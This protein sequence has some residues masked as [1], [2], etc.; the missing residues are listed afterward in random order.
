MFPAGIGSTLGVGVYVIAGEVAKSMAGP[1]VVLSFL[2]AAIASVFA[3]YEYFEFTI[4]KWDPVKLLFVTKTVLF[5]LISR[6]CYA[7]FSARVPK[8]GSAYV[9]S[10]VTIGEFIAFVIGWNLI[11]EYSIGSASVVKGMSTYIDSLTGMN[12]I[13]EENLPIHIS[14]MA[15]FPDVFAFSV[16]ML[17]SLA[18]AFGARES[19]LMNNVFTFLNLSVV[20]FVIIAGSLKADPNNWSIPADKVPPK[21][22]DGGFFPYGWSGVFKGAATCFYGFIGFDCIA[23]AGEEAKNPR[24]SMPLAI[25]V[26]LFVIF[27]AY[28][29]ISTVLTM[30]LPYYMQ[31]ENAPLPYVFRYYGWET[32]AWAVSIGAIFG[33]CASLLGS[34]FPLPRIVYAMAS[35]GLIFKWL[36]RIN[37]RFHT[38]LYGT[39]FVGLLT[40]SLAAFLN[41]SQ[42][43]NMMSLGTLIAYSIVAACVLLLR[44]EVDDEDEKLHVP[45]PFCYN[46]HRFLCNSF[47]LQK[48]TKLTS[49]I[50]TC[51]V[52][53]FCKYNRWLNDQRLSGI[54]R[55]FVFSFF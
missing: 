55:N 33:L 22:G 2:I 14:G 40:A 34:M 15:E 52:T 50:A 38:P 17:F 26:S 19:S 49:L 10:Y 43:V 46:F 30:M 39:L 31:N 53:L 32:A 16:T 18:L 45:A 35:D 47:N 51:E 5:W 13:F 41:L 23:T 7:E 42:L 11:L 1:A 6:L 54:F 3:G 48:P 37:A 24:K 9:Y 8:A 20:L 36:G 25:I 29:G 12:R 21:S 27:L 4:F 44:Y 28:F